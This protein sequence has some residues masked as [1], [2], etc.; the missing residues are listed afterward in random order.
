MSYSAQFSE[1]LLFFF[2]V[3]LY[4]CFYISYD[5]QCHTAAMW[6]RQTRSWL[7]VKEHD[8][9]RITWRLPLVT[10]PIYG[11]PSSSGQREDIFIFMDRSNR[12]RYFSWWMISINPFEN[13]VPKIFITKLWKE[14]ALI[15][16][17]NM[18][19][20]GEL[21]FSNFHPESFGP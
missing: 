20:H 1:N 19:Y 8:Q 5:L 3:M 10:N 11:L 15:M 4:S 2:E 21:I 13:H 16:Q 9:T 12:Q 14:N 7:M 6:M 17:W 18:L